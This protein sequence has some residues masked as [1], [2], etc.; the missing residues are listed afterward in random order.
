MCIGLTACAQSS[1]NQEEIKWV[2]LEEADALRRTEPR[3]IL[4]DVYTDW[5][6][7]CKKMDASTFKDP[8][9]VAYI[10]A[11]YY[12]VKLDAEQKEPI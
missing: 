10:N 8:K 4:I 9:V 12:A 7:W 2:S 1:K 6:G 5:C 11:N 3:K